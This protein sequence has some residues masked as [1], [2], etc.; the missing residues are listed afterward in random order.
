VVDVACDF[1]R[2]RTFQVK[3]GDCLSRE[4][5]VTSGVPQGSVIGP[6][7]FSILLHDFPWGIESTV[8]LFADDSVVY[9]NIKTQEDREILQ[10]DLDRIDN[11]VKE[12]EMSLNVKKCAIVKFGR[13]KTNPG[14]YFLGQEEIE[15]R[16]SYKYLGFILD[17][18]CD[19]KENT[20]NAVK[21]AGRATDYV[22]RNLRG[23]GIEMR[24]KAYTTLVRPIIEYTSTVADPHKQCD[25]KEMEA[26]QRRAAR[27]ALGI[28]RRR[29]EEGNYF[30]VTEMV[31]SLGWD[32][33]Q[34][35]RKVDRLCG[36]YRA[37]NKFPGWSE[38]TDKLVKND[39]PNRGGH[40]SRL[41]E[42]GSRTD[43]GKFSFINRSTRD[44]NG[45]GAEQVG[46]KGVREFRR[47]TL[48]HLQQQDKI[49]ESDQFIYY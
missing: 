36:M 44:W 28:Y 43:V 1:L 38:I 4:V 23:A 40:D 24:Q 7:L 12:N 14:T 13:I 18:Q 48:Q 15:L 17:S 45:L 30:S 49:E 26:V 34:T 35:R 22:M 37:Y 27:R 25:I 9:R 20:N 5:R 19:W 46:A 31:K 41:I 32:T 3:V 11:W 39:R 8:R 6:I 21:K 29:D 16:G 42:K 47:R 10:R 33:L 2:G